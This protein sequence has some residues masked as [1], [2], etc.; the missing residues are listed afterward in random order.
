VDGEDEFYTPLAR[1]PTDSVRAIRRFAIDQG[2]DLVVGHH[3]HVV[4]GLEVYDGHLIAHSLGDFTFD[5]DYP[6]TYPSMILNAS[7][8]E[9]GFRDFTVTPVYIDEYI[10]VRARGELGD[11]ILDY[12]ARRSRELGA[13]LVVDRDSGR[14]R[15][16]LDTLA[17]SPTVNPGN[18]ELDLSSEGGYSVSTPLRLPGLGSL[19]SVVSVTP[20]RTWQYRVGREMVWWGNCEDEG[21]TLWLLTQAG[22]G[23]DTIAHRGRRSVLQ[24]RGE[25]SAAL[26]TDFEERIPCYSDSARY[27]LHGWIR[28][29]NAE[30]AGI[31]AKFYSSRPSGSAI[32]TADLDTTVSGTAG[33][34]FFHKE[35]VP[36]S[37]TR[38]FDVWLRSRGPESGEGSAWY[39]DVGIIEW[40]GWHTLSGPAPIV[41]PNDYQWVQV[42]TV[43]QTTSATLSYEETDYCLPTGVGGG[44]AAVPGFRLF[45][46][47]PNPGRGGSQIRYSLARPGRVSLKVYNSL[48]QEVRT[49]VSGVE[50]AGLRL[51][52]WDGRDNSGRPA[53]AGTYF[54]RLESGGR[55]RTGEVVLLR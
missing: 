32:G 14:A 29:D 53:A 38:Y 47:F 9:T 42:R 40:E 48:G 33:W 30:S 1:V 46:P 6:E 28:T 37:G 27:S 49:L 54:C 45:R 35:L 16:A 2:A 12:L 11:Y 23:Y 5:L 25:R 50:P 24:V 19:S 26:V 39:D 13:Y 10:P 34:A 20:A 31:A 8:D 18:A 4:Q 44:D 7:V 17:L 21:S 3:P 22:E 55:S 36:V 51:A 52:R 15:I 43:T 41:H